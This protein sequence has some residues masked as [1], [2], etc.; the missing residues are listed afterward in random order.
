MAK[1]KLIVSDKS[2]KAQIVELEGSRAVPLIGRRIGETVDGSIANLA[3]SK[4]QILGGTDKDGF[5]MR[6]DIQGGVKTRVILTEGIGFH[7]TTKGQRK[8]KTIR[9]NTITEDIVQINLRLVEEEKAQ[10]Q[11]R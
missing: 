3:G 6:R 7:A 1:F 8:R 2:G 10:P 9:G 5:P 4:L 11:T